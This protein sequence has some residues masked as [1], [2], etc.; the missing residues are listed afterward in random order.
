MDELNPGLTGT[1]EWSVTAGMTASQVGSGLVAVFSTPMLA[2]LM[3]NAAVDALAAYLDED[4]TSVGTRIDVRHLAATPVGM[5][6]R[7]RATLAEID[8]RRL[9]F[10]VEAW[11]AVEKIGEATHE[12]VI[13]DR[14]RFEAR[15]RE[16]G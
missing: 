6:V 16:K 11:D 9:I 4:Q 14:A 12:R 15:A 10:Q 1:C 2:A 8:Q 3:E 13:V 5:T 7:A